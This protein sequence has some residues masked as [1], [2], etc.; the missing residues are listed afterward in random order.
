M[1]QITSLVGSRDFEAAYEKACRRLADERESKIVL[2]AH[3]G[4]E[5]PGAEAAMAPWEADVA[6]EA[7]ILEELRPPYFIRQDKIVIDGSYDHVDAIRANLPEL[8]TATKSVG[9]VDLVNHLTHDFVGTGWLI[10]DGIAITNRHVARTF[11]ETDWTGRFPFKV[12]VGGAPVS[13]ELDLLRQSGTLGRRVVEVSSVLYIAGDREPDFAFL[14]V[15]GAVDALPLRLSASLPGSGTPV[16]AIGYPAWDGHRNDPRLMAELFGGIYDV[17]RFCPGLLT[18]VASDGLVAMADYTSLGG[19]SGSP[20]VNL[21]NSEVVGL[22]FAG[23]F[24]EAN[25]LVTPEILASALGTVRSRVVVTGGSQEVKEPVVPLE[26]LE[27]R[28]GYDPEFLG[29]GNLRVDLPG[30]GDWK[31]DIAP[32]AGGQDDVLRYEHFSV[33]QCRS[34]RLPLFTAVNIDG[35]QQRKLNR[36]GDWRLD[37]RLDLQDQVGNELY[38]GNALDR[39]HMV[40]RRDPGWGSESEA[41]RGEEDTFYYTNCVPQHEDLNQKDWVGLEDYILGAAE[42]LGFK[43]S[44]FTGPVFRASD[45]RLVDQPG[46]EDVAIPEEFWKVAVMISADT[47]SLHSTAYVLSHGAMIRDMLEAAFV[48]GKHETYQVPIALV[49]RET[50]LDFGR[51]RQFDPMGHTEGLEH[52]PAVVRIRGPEDLIL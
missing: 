40:R 38:R 25:Y 51:L 5:L 3:R 39:G 21:T 42:T 52:A 27:G 33:V 11:A 19:S 50:G 29:G 36:R 22:H 1:R 31:A 45:R 17:K 30:L 35:S 18:G 7:I 48:Y 32:V 14:K 6:L 41:R 10:W 15:E 47:G 12:G 28:V 26:S 9:R 24:R 44:V 20:V 23:V 34:R 8:E 43:A 49:E 4:L 46:A 16:A 2:E 37:G 13:A